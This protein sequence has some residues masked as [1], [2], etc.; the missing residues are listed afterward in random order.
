MDL[1]DKIERGSSGKLTVNIYN[2]DQT[3]LIDPDSQTVKL[4]DKNGKQVG[5]NLTP[6]KSDI[7][8]YYVIVEIDS[9]AQ[10]GTWN[11]DWTVVYGNISSRKAFEFEVVK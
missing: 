5:S 4:M 10:L 3:T 1:T 6:T 11:V 8:I 2:F 9:E 7:G